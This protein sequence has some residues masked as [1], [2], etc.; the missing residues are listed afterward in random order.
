MRESL[1]Q[2]TI[3]ITT[4]Y[5]YK[6]GSLLPFLFS[7]HSKIPHLHPRIL[8]HSLLPSSYLPPSQQ[9]QPTNTLS[10]THTHTHIHTHIIC[11]LSQQHSLG[12]YP[13]SSSCLPLSPG[14]S[15]PTRLTAQ[16]CPPTSSGTYLQGPLASSQSPSMKTRPS[17]SALFL[18]QRPQYATRPS[19]SSLP[20]PSQ[21]RQ[22]RAR[23]HQYLPVHRQPLLD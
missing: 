20:L 12:S 19:S 21:K 23:L 6:N 2:S 5:A 3:T 14:A 16:S 10:L 11:Q 8:I 9:T 17:P 18:S 7:P 1:S 15:T 4:K 13:A 22:P